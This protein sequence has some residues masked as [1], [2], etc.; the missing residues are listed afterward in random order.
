MKKMLLAVSLGFLLSLAMIAKSEA[1]IVNFDDLVGQAAVPNGYGGITTWTDWTYYSFAQPPY[2]PH[3]DFV[4]IYDLSN[5]NAMDWSSPVDF[6]G[7]WIAGQ[8][9]TTVRFDGY[10]ANVLQSSSSTI[11]AS[12]TPT[13]LSANFGTQVDRVVVISNAPDFFI[14]DDVTYNEEGTP[15]VIP[16][17]ASLSLLGIGLIGLIRKKLTV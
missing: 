10:L 9:F 17:P 15:G 3:S 5:N 14:L 6:Q 16:E 4:R 2:T 8:D 1:V 13:F 12:S 7:A 11:N